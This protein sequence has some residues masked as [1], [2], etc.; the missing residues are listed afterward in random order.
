MEAAEM[1][2]R[3]PTAMPPRRRGG[4]RGYGLGQAVPSI[5]MGA[6]AGWTPESMAPAWM[7]TETISQAI[8]NALGVPITQDQAQQIKNSAVN[9]TQ[10]ACGQF[11]GT[12]WCQDQMQQ[13]AQAV[14]LAVQQSNQQQAG[15][16]YN[17]YQDLTGTGVAGASVLTWIG[18]GVIGLFVILQLVK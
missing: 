11:V 14:T 3:L 10:Q 13:T 4:G 18:L 12:Q 7:S 16:P 6:P 15:F 17:V 9:S 2:H 1:I 8:Q 5:A